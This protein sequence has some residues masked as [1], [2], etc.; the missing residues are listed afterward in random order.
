MRR[1][2]YDNLILDL[3]GTVY[4]D[5]VPIG[6]VVEK[7]NALADT[8]VNLWVITNNTSVGKE[9]YRSKLE[10]LGLHIDRQRLVTPMDVTGVY[11]REK[12]GPSPRG[13][14]LGTEEFL[15]ELQSEWGVTHDEYN[16]AFVLVT[17]DQTLTYQKLRR[18]CEHITRGTVYYATNLDIFCP[19]HQGPIPDTGSLIELIQ[20]VTGI[21]VAE[22]FGKP[23]R[24]LVDFLRAKMPNLKRV[25]L[26]GDR[27]YTDI[28]FGTQLGVDTLLVFSGDST[29]QDLEIAKVKP[30]YTA[31]TLWEFLS[32][33]DFAHRLR[34]AGSVRERGVN[35]G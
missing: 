8:G 27:L 29:R 17:F 31:D 25:L 5:G 30:T 34:T 13:Y 22:H 19:T 3:D 16:P 20:T 11:L 28:E 35:D 18:A 10:S 26:A 23:S 7:L 33:T 1:F 15:R 32:R 6:P 21:R 12:Y 2:P 14:L 4:I 9:Q 24:H